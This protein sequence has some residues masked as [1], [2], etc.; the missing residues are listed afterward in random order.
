V[1]C[2]DQSQTDEAR[3]QVANE[4]P[5]AVDD[6]ART[7]QDTS[8]TIDVTGND[9]DPD[10]DEGYKTSLE[11]TQP[12]NGR[13]EELPG[14]QIR[15]TPDPGFTGEDPFTYTFCDIDVDANGGKDCDKATV[16][17]TV[18]VER[19]PVDPAI[20]SVTPEASRPTT[21]WWSRGPLGPAA[22]RPG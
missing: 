21:R 10:G 19:R 20:G 7:R 8:V 2:D 22:R 12:L 13:T 4:A 14:G 3:L 18:T 16:T 11:A 15:Y 5:D 6:S 17:V 9:T 1:D